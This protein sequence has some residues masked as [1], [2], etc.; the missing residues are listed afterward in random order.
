MKVPSIIMGKCI[1]KLSKV[2]GR[3]GSAFPGLAVERT[4]PRFITEVFKG[5]SHGVVVISGTNGKT[6]TTKIVS[7]LLEK[8]GLKVFTNKSGSNFVRGIIS[9]ILNNISL[10]GKFDFDI[11]VLELDEAH[12][13]QFCKVIEIDYA[14]M[15]NVQRDQLDR[16]GEIDHTADLLQKV[17]AKARKCAVLNR[18]DHRVAALKANR[19]VFFGLSDEL[20]PVFMTR[21]SLPDDNVNKPDAKVRLIS[22][23]GSTHHAVYEYD[24][25]HMEV[26]LTVQGNYNAFNS[27]GALSLVSEIC[28]DVPMEK[29]VG[30][31][32]GIQSAFGRGETIMINDAPVKLLLSKNPSSMQLSVNAFAEVEE[33]CDYMVVINDNDADG[34]DVS[35][36]WDVDFSKLP[37]VAMTAGNRGADMALVSINEEF[38]QKADE[39]STVLK[40]GD[41]VEFLYFMGGGQ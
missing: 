40:E 41:S 29:L 39:A 5:L 7:E 28:P 36:L 25:K 31:L 11:A 33:D 17:V 14:M 21:D 16:F 18:E 3:G 6:T 35:W 1:Q 2:T 38:I 22:Y 30:D 27:A 23:K 32:H 10:G 13:V 12:A 34:H 20:V 4:N 24:G 8:Q 15:L 37:H 9:E 26:D 19:T